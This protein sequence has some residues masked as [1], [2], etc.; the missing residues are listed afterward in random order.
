MGISS[1]ASMRAAA[2]SKSSRTSIRCSFS[3]AARRRFTSSGLI[4][5]G[6]AMVLYSLETA[7][8]FQHP[9]NPAPDPRDGGLFH[10]RGRLGR[11]HGF[12]LGVFRGIFRPVFGDQG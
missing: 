9:E 11:L 6:I 10:R 3:P 12:F 2:Y 5:I 1:L 8:A 4:S 7:V